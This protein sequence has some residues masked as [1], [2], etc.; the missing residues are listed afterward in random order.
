MPVASAHNQQAGFSPG[1]AARLALVDGR[2]VFV[3][4]IGPDVV[5]GAPGGQGSYR[6]EARITAPL[7]TVP[8]PALIN[9][10]EAGGWVILCLED[11]EGTNPELPWQ[12]D[13]LAR[14]LGALTALAGASAPSPLEAPA[15][16]TQGRSD[17]WP[18]LASEGARRSRGC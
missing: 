18:Q 15:A 16:A 6:R 7:P 14:V 1:L 3:K 13:Q 4:A 2:R 9:T 12:D 10:W 8:A 17:R 5:S 11:I